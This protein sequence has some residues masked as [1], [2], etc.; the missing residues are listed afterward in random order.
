LLFGA[1]SVINYVMPKNRMVRYRATIGLLL[2]LLVTS[3]MACSILPW[4]RERSPYTK[5]EVSR[6]SD[7]DIYIID[8]E[9][10]LKVPSGTDE[11]GNVQFHYV[12]VD[13]YLAGEV[14]PLPLEQER[15]RKEETQEVARTTQ[16][17]ESVSTQE[18]VVQG[19]EVQESPPVTTRT[20][21]HPYLKRKIAILPFED[22][23]QFTLEKF[24]EVIADRLTKKMEDEVFTS[25]VIDREMVRL[26][27]ARSGLTAQ[28]L[29]NP[30][31][32]T[33]LNKTLG[34]Q[35]VIV[36]TVYGPFVTT[37]DPVEYEK[38]SMAIVKVAVKFIDTS[39]GRVMKEFVATNPLGG[40]EE[41][42]ELSEERAK[43]R[44]VD[45]AVDQ[46]IAQLV[47]EIQGMDWLTRIALV[48][49]NTVY[50]NAGNRTGLKAGDLLE[51]YSAGDVDGARPIGRIKVSKL[52]GVDAAV[53]QVIRGRV[54]VNAVVKPLP[55]S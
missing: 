44:A 1:L 51:V 33:V 13:R 53:A 32:T 6:L 22:R 5:E 52:F 48:E 31:K 35:G 20:I 3:V 26:T 55:Q 39:Q 16:E 40:S 30:S 45:L 12:K 41:F 50:L 54:Q 27:L 18:P 11:Q 36:G 24:G 2:V 15:V 17:A 21:K 7:K 49:G 10:Y 9:K 23:T 29:S 34:I 37:T 42:G 4:K 47:S 38:T 43:Y 25:Q 19:Q 14:E 8:G 46:I 28:D